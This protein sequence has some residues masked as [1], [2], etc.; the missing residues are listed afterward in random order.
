[1]T[2]Q[3][4]ELET[5]EEWDDLLARSPDRTPYHRSEFLSTCEEYSNTRL[6]AYVGYKG[7]EPVGL[8]PVFELSK[9][10]F[11][12]AFSPSPNLK[13]PYLGP[14]LVP[15]PGIK[16]RKLELR[17]K[18]F[19]EAVL[20]RI[21]A[22]IR[23]RYSQV[24]TAPS[25]TDDRPFLW[26]GYET[27]NRYTY[28]VDLTQSE[29]DLVEAFSKD[30]RRNV[31]TDEAYEVHQGDVADVKRVLKSVRER[32]DEQDIDLS[33]SGAFPADLF[34]RLPDECMTVHVCT[35]NGTFRGGEI[36]LQDDETVYG[37]LAAGDHSGDLPVNDLVTWHVM[38]ESKRE[39]YGTYDMIGANNPRLSSY[40]SKFGPELESYSKLTKKTLDGHILSTLYQWMN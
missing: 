9:G 8:F 37:W 38:R 21:E 26:E 10:P 22:D 27:S 18:N 31:R 29:E 40:K 36:T 33:I 4:E 11:A 1:M 39:G 19:V 12:A 2:I 35:Q 3:V 15:S 16:R 7:Q 23:P 30:A 32:H 34:R 5:L 20:S 25:Y 17:N 6:R 28:C 24:R 14:A 13:I